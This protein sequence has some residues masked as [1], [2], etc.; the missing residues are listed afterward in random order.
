MGYTVGL[1]RRHIKTLSDLTNDI[2]IS[3]GFM[4]L[5]QLLPRDA[6]LALFFAVVMSVCRSIRRHKPALYQNG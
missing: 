1:F 6:M 3:L 5:I 4:L 2:L